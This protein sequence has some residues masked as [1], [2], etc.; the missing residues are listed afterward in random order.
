MKNISLMKEI[1]D[2]F[3]NQDFQPRKGLVLFFPT[4]AGPIFQARI[5]RPSRQPAIVNPSSSVENSSCPDLVDDDA[6]RLIVVVTIN[7][8]IPFFVPPPSLP[9]SS[10]QGHNQNAR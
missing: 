6:K 4:V 8:N 10:F 9:T 2:S 5:R 3:Q 7:S 1:S